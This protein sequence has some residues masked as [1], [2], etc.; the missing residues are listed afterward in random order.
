MSIGGEIDQGTR[1]ISSHP[2]D[3]HRLHVSPRRP[4][5]WQETSSDFRT[6]DRYSLVTKKRGARFQ[7]LKH[8]NYF[9]HVQMDRFFSIHDHF[10]IHQLRVF[11]LSTFSQYKHTPLGNGEHRQQCFAFDESKQTCLNNVNPDPDDPNHFGCRWDT[12]FGCFNVACPTMGQAEGLCLAWRDNPTLFPM[13]MWETL[14]HPDSIPQSYFDQLREDLRQNNP[15]F[16]FKN[17]FCC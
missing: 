9:N 15:N 1:L 6:S 13:C 4:A 8:R 12:N 5:L 11:R 7:N 14:P 2:S 17:D 16:E 3:L 10:S